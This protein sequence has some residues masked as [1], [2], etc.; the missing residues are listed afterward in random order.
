M[1][2]HAHNR[3]SSPAQL[4]VVVGEAHSGEAWVTG[5]VMYS[6]CETTAWRQRGKQPAFFDSR[7]KRWLP[8]VPHDVSLWFGVCGDGV[9]RFIPRADF[10]D[11]SKLCRSFRRNGKAGGV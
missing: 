6:W 1:Q 7:M 5:G 10:K 2:R 9:L 8:A 3:R 4:A 11:S